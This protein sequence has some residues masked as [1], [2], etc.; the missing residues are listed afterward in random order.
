MRYIR[1]P[2]PLKAM[3]VKRAATIRHPTH[4]HLRLQAQNAGRSMD[5][6]N[7]AHHPPS[8]HITSDSRRLQVGCRWRDS[9]GSGES[10]GQ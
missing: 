3:H 7:Y 5:E 8:P 1:G 2:K 10:S 9:G 6:R 4:M